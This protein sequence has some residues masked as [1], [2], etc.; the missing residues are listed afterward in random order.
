M[1]A[2]TQACCWMRNDSA[3]GAASMDG[4]RDRKPADL[5]PTAKAGYVV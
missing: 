5:Q 1:T 2:G 3:E 4:R